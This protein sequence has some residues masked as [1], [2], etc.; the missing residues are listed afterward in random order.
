VKAENCTVREA[1]EDELLAVVRLL[2]AGMLAIDRATVATAIG[3]GDVLVAVDGRRV[4][5][6]AVLSPRETG[7]HVEAIAV[8]RERR[9]RGIGRQLIEAACERHAQVTADFRAELEPF[10][11]SLGFA[12]ERRGTRLWGER[13]TETD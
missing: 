8:Q 4:V 13:G 5:G 11:A 1:A 6:A 3:R 10:W 12:V 7:A 2:D 9:D